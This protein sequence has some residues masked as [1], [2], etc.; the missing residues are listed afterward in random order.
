MNNFHA[1]QALVA[2]VAANGESKVAEREE[3]KKRDR[4]WVEF[5]V[6]YNIISIRMM[7]GKLIKNKTNANQN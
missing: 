1:P 7:R 2:A 3:E 4:D 6:C 5:G